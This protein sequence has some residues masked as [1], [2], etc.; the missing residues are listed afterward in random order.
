MKM[1]TDVQINDGAVH[2]IEQAMMRAA[3]KAIDATLTDVTAAQ[4]MP[5]DTGDMQ[6]NR[7]YTAFVEKKRSEITTRVI[8]DAPQARRLYYHPEYNFQTVNNPNA[9]AKWFEP[10]GNGGERSDFFANAFRKYLNE[11]LKK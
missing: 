10:W 7:T 9:G 2:A 4:V 11:E 3:E 5:F 6:D 8:T 1:R